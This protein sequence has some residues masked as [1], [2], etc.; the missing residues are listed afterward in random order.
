M[1][2]TLA[3]ACHDFALSLPVDSKVG[4]NQTPGASSDTWH[5]LVGEIVAS[6]YTFMNNSFNAS[7]HV[8][9]LNG[10]YTH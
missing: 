5:R 9:V 6:I 2:Y 7:G 1:V 8:D 4:G 3:Q 10:Q